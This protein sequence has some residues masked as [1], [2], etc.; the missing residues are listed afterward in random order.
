[1]VRKL[2]WFTVGFTAACAVGIYAFCGNYLVLLCLLLFGL[3]ALCFAWKGIAAQ[4]LRLVFLGCGA[5]FLWVWLFHGFYLVDAQKLD[6]QKVECSVQ[7]IDYSEPTDW[8][9]RA[10]GKVKLEGKT[11]RI[12]VYASQI[13][14]L[15]PGDTVEGVFELSATFAPDTEISYHSANG[16]YLL[17]KLSE[18]TNISVPGKIPLV[19]Y[20]AVLRK[21]IQEI[22]K[23]SF[24]ED[25]AGFAGALL[26]GDRTGLEYP[27][28]SALSVSGIR[29]VVAVSGLHVSILFS[30][31]VLIFGYRRFVTPIV[32]GL[33]LLLFAAVT[34][35]T[36][37]V[38]RAGIMHGLMLGAMALQKEYDPP[39][40][41]SF[42]VMTLL[43]VNP[44]V[45]TSIGFQ[46]SVGC[47][48]GIFLFSG[49]IRQFILSDKCLG[50]PRPKTLSGKLKHWIAGSVSMTLS[51]WITTTPLCAMYFGTISLIGVFTNLLTLWLITLIFWGILVVCI[52]SVIFLPLG[53]IAAWLL[54]WP[55][56]FVLQ[57]A[58]LFASF[59]LAAVYTE[60]VYV[61]V[62]LVFCYVLFIAYLLMKK[63]HPWVLAFCMTVSLVIAVAASWVEPKLDDYRFTVLDV[64]QGQSILIQSR[65]KHYL[66][67]CGGDLDEAAAD[68]AAQTLLSQ[69]ITRLDGVILTH[70]DYDHAGSVAYVLSQIPANEMFLPDI[71]DSGKYRAALEKLGG[72]T[73]TW[74]SPDSTRII[75]DTGITLYTTKLQNS[76]NE[77]SM[78]ILFQPGNCDILITGDKG[79]SGEKALLAHTDL[80]DL[81][82]LVLGHHGAKGVATLELL[83]KTRPE[84][85]LVSVG[86]DNLY[87]HPAQDVL[88]RLELF[89]CRV[90]R[91]DTDGTL[92]VRG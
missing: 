58:R 3:A 70:Y 34:G 88:E 53:Q 78:C 40:A 45:I 36:P 19:C 59:P 15:S 21:D 30:L 66:I 83:T 18:V 77:N 76:D 69:G 28:L 68:K 8:G 75:E 13:D 57:I 32:G 86:A 73:I 12:R 25:T 31:V 55:I 14:S 62:W 72:N 5:A 87:G 35:L 74:I 43:A 6:G 20:P 82:V 65:G 81:E 33:L 4:I 60:S 80:P 52:M 85:V 27:T 38:V 92:T 9:I 16:I 39:T 29:H 56:R 22:L 67:D 24:P 10:D 63:K 54:S 79:P 47:L 2:M 89:G 91:T 90:L 11:Y 48:V 71:P 84:V 1:M 49:P 17:G 37:S 42:A 7:I 41:L 44:V 26:L 61:V 46:L 51:T 23:K 50:S 64:G